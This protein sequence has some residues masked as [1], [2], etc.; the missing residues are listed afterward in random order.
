[1]WKSILKFLKISSSKFEKIEREGPSRI[2]KLNLI[3]NN[4]MKKIV[5]N[6]LNFERIINT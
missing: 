6:V 5:K 2:F 1:M 3:K 4:N